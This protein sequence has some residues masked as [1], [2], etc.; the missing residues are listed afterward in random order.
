[1]R[2]VQ[3][4]VEAPRSTFTERRPLKMFLGYMALMSSIIDLEPSSFQEVGDK[5]VRRDA[6]MDE[7][8]SIQKN[9]IWDIVPTLEGKSIVSSKWLY[10]I[11]HATDGV[12]EKFKARFVE[13]GFS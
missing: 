4:Y 10:K 2:D 8:A 13:R 6:M 5:N 9:D 1:L 11:K 3:E 12:I 7:Y